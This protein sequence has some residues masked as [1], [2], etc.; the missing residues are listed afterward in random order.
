LIA[1]LPYIT[2]KIPEKYHNA[3]AR[4]DHKEILRLLE[5]SDH[6]YIGAL[7]SR[8]GCVNSALLCEE[9]VRYLLKKYPD[10][11][12]V[13]EH[14]PVHSLT[15]GTESALITV[16]E[17]DV[18]AQ[19]VILC[20]NGFSNFSITSDK[21]TDIDFRFHQAILGKISY[22]AAYTEKT[23]RPPAA[24]SYFS[25]S[26]NTLSAAYDR[27]R[28]LDEQDPYFYL[29][30]RPFKHTTKGSTNLVCI[31]GPE[32]QDDPL[33]TYN[34]QQHMYPEDAR[35]AITDFMHQT[36]AP[37]PVHD[38][39]YTFLWHGLMGYTKNGL[40]CIGP[41]PKNPV[42]LYNIG[43]NGVGILSS[44]Y[45]GKRISNFLLYKKLEP[46]IFDPSYSVG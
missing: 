36:F 45:G 46:S 42:L 12:E 8:K 20:T 6:R 25:P 37:F 15:L 41:D 1:G 11:F 39:D 40:R 19:K 27:N 2:Q 38:P 43:C 34:A 21:Q 18:S 32:S 13:F 7:A 5:T 29:T 4:V 23:D 10:R 9:I 31:G 24:I 22:M 44:I 17:Y 26:Q 35:K 33:P 14:S 16:G 3:Y 30:R 28:S